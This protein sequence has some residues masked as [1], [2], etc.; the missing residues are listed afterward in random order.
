MYLEITPGGSKRWFW[1]YRAGGKEFRMALGSY[2]AV[3][4]TAA[5]RAHR[6]AALTS[7]RVHHAAGCRPE[8]SARSRPP[9]GPP[10]PPRTTHSCPAAA[11]AHPRTPMV[12]PVNPF[13]PAS[14][15]P[16]A[17]SACGWPAG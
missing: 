3:S 5:R 8:N 11:T 17:V 9:Q 4:L 7:L 10:V 6:H 12:A 16:D 1:K 14:R 13:A 2:P 15:C